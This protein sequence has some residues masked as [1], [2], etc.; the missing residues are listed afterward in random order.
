MKFFMKR[1][2]LAFLF[3]LC[4]PLNF[5]A[6]VPDSRSRQTD[7][8]ITAFDNPVID[9]KD[10]KKIPDLYFECQI[11]LISKD[12]SIPLFYNSVVREYIEI[13]LMGRKKQ[14]PELCRL[15]QQY[16]P[17]FES[18]L[19][20]EGL[21]TELKYIAVIESGL[22]PMALS[23]SGAY[24]LWQFKAE[25]GKSFGLQI[26][27]SIDER[28]DPQKS[29][30][31]ACSYL[32]YLYSIFGDWKLSL[33]AYHAG[34]TTIKNAIKKAGGK[35]SYNDIC[36]FLPPPTQRYLPAYIAIMYVLNN[37]QVHL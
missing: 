17:I 31:A 4:I 12:G 5:A 29:T 15:S 1:H 24:G 34:P 7:L 14:I 10:V 8:M 23:P 18:R 27:E 22:N 32:K 16:F 30:K 26:D 25:T 28:T 3:L 2:I 35:T 19:Q 9:L 21:P 36:Q 20:M 37:Y 13:Y 33:L 6:P 11:A